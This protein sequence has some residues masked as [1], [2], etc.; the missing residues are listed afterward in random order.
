LW[1]NQFIRINNQS[2]CWPQWNRAGISQI[3]DLL[4]ES[5]IFLS[6]GSLREKYGLNTNFLTLLQIR[7]AIPH[8]WHVI[9]RNSIQ[10]TNKHHDLSCELKLNGFWREIKKNK[11]SS[12][13]W[14]F[15]KKVEIKTNEVKWLDELDLSTVDF[16][17]I[18]QLPYTITKYTKLQSFQFKI[19]HR[20]INTNKWLFIRNIV[21]SN[22]CRFCEIVEDI[23]HFFIDCE[24]CKLLW[25]HILTW[26]NT[27][28]VP[29]LQ[30]IGK[31]D[32]IFGFT[33][34]HDIVKTLN[35]VLLYAKIFIYKCRTRCIK[36]CMYDFLVDFKNHLV[37]VARDT[38]KTQYFSTTLEEFLA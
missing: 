25:N 20:I 28:D 36:P 7:Q 14:S 8:S 35:M 37:L 34:T 30:E 19:I 5:N 12:Y 32:I 21:D 10:Q 23:V 16:E 18:Y 11:S 2:F 22:K 31:A 24:S 29:F 6:E 17:K 4:D 13:Y 38:S 9:L 3:K 27:L 33:A 15:I 26:W 1:F